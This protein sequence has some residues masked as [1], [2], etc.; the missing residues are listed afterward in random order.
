MELGCVFLPH[1]R[2]VEKNIRFTEKFKVKSGA[3]RKAGSM[4]RFD[5][6]FEPWCEY[7]SGV[8]PCFSV[9]LA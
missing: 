8:L 5:S 3:E 9:N 6:Q 1:R 4:T 7:F 2:G